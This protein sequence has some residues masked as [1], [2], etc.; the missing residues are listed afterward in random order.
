M[1][2]VNY[3]RRA[4][5]AEARGEYCMSVDSAYRYSL[6]HYRIDAAAQKK[7][8]ERAGFSDMAVIDVDGRWL[9]WPEAERRE[10]DPWFQY[11][12][13]RKSERRQGD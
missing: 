3:L 6:I 5:R 11:S 2:I 10:R 13:R 8:L 4:H 1:G 9:T 12:C 7:Q